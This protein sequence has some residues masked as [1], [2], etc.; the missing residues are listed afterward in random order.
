MTV[1]S[2]LWIVDFKKE[3]AG[4]S[5][6]LPAARYAGPYHNDFVGDAVV[7][8]ENGTLVLKLG[9]KL[10]A[11]PLTHFDRDTFTYQPE[12]EMSAGLSGVT[13]RI[14]PDRV[15]DAV[16]LENLNVHGS[17]TLTRVP[18]GK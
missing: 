2:E 1:R 15:A 3:P 16:T 8:E 18:A 7:A 14:G 4:K 6:P 10:R 17:G 11:F 13:F 9:S 12:G 5:L